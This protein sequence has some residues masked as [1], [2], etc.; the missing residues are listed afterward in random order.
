MF[1]KQISELYLIQTGRLKA[2]YP[3]SFADVMIAAHAILED[4]TSV[5]KDP[6]FL[7]LEKEIRLQMLPFKLSH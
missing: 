2:K 5:H 1:I 7:S 6:E 4:A 3:I